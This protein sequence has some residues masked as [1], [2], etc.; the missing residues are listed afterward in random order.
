[1]ESLVEL[2]LHV[3]DFYQAFPS[4]SKQYL[5]QSGVIQRRRERSL[6]LSEVMTILIHFHQSHY[7]NFKTYY[8]E[9]V[10]P[11]LHQEFPTLVSYT[12][13]VDFIPYALFPLCAYF[14]K[15]YLGDCTGISFIDSTS[16]EVCL[17]QP[18]ASHKILVIRVT[19]PCYS[20]I[21]CGK[22]SI[23]GWS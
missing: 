18:I 22:H 8:C 17:T 16:L 23:A 9:Y 6:A 13:F 12:R 14:H 4:Q 19:S 10:W 7:R 2:F 11:H 20:M 15:T 1:M 5:F 21:C 3:D